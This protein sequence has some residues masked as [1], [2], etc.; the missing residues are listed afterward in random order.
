[1]NLQKSIQPLVYVVSI[2]V[3]APDTTQME[4]QDVLGAAAQNFLVNIHHVH[5]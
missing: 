1:M 2:V 4:F 3:Y 5:S